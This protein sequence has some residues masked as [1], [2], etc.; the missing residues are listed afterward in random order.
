[1]LRYTTEAFGECFRVAVF[2]SGADF[3]AA[4]QGVPSGIGPL[5]L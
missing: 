5:N 4:T 1:M 2:A 3:R